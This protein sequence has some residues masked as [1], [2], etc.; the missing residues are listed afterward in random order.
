MT[1]KEKR[2]EQMAKGMEELG[3]WLEDMI[4]QGLGQLEGQGAQSLD[5]F[6]ARMVDAK[7]GSIGRRIRNWKNLLEQPAWEGPLLAEMGELFLLVRAFRQA[8]ALPEELLS[9]L[10]QYAG[11]SVRKE[12]LLAGPLMEGQ[13]AVI[14]IAAGDEEN[15]RFR[16]T[17]LQRQEDGSFALL[18]DFSFGGQPFERNWK[19]GRLYAGTL[20]FYPSAY[21]Q[22]AAA[23]EL[24]RTDAEGL[25]FTGYLSLDGL[26][27]QYAAA[28]QVQ[29]WLQRFPALLENV[30]PLKNDKEDWLLL[31]ENLQSIAIGA[32]GPT[33]WT[34]LSVS[35]ARPIDVFGEWNGATFQPLSC[36]SAGRLIGLTPSE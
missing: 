1:N 6:A 5:R 26:S 36:L 29:P 7:L 23:A 3:L 16:R 30:R 20:A 31:D 24:N 15:L 17:W 25:P 22:R 33:G 35:G 28:L 12:E 4:R 11:L 21:P 13:W 27:K 9:D 14:G 34:L 19:L 18:L 8:E 32:E 10:L 2:L